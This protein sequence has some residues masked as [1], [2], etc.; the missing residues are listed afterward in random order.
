MIQQPHFWV[1]IQRKWNHYLYLNLHVHCSNFG[2]SQ[3]WKQ[4][5]CP[6]T[7]EWIKKIFYIYI[8]VYIYT[9]YIYI[10]HIYIYGRISFSHEKE[11]SLAIYNNT[12]GP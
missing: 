10:Y 4:S 3:E 5:N 6:S 2:K 7:D 12:D 1:Y 11:R 9:L 8:Y